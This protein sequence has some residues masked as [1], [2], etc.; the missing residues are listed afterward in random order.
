MKRPLSLAPILVAIVFPFVSVQACGPFFETDLFVRTIRPD[1]PAEYASGKLGILLP[2]FPRADLIVAWRYL[3]GGSL[4]REEQQA[5][6]PAQSFAEYERANEAA[7]EPKAPDGT[8]YAESPGAA[9]EWLKARNRYAPAQP[10]IHTVKD[11]YLTWTAG[12]ILAGTYEN[13][14]ADAFRTAVLTLNNRARTWGAK[15]PELADWIRGQDTVFSNCGGGFGDYPPGKPK[16]S[17]IAPSPAP[18]NAPALLRQDRAYQLAAAHFYAGE[19]VPARESFQAIA[20][21]PDS[22]WRGIAAY[23]TA[24]TF[25]RDSFLTAKPKPGAPPSDDTAAFDPDLMRQA[26]QQLESIRNRN[27]PGISPHAIQSMLNLVRIRTEPKARLHELA[28]A[29]SGPKPDPD[30][31][32]DREDLTWYLNSKADSL[33]VREDAWDELFHVKRTSSNDGPLTPEEKK[34]GFEQALEHP[35]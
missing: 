25:I 1:H 8:Y 12:Y 26:Q 13:C 5:Y 19:L 2:T 24:R 28:V 32:Q 34:P 20:S 11:S 27:L 7:T 30:Y 23:L 35:A 31:K 6:Q 15:S 29:L 4:T 10:V 14:Q 33:P 16:I 9:D 22:P 18:A 3:N 21:D 17:Q